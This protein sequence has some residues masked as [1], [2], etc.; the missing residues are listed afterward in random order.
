M[1]NKK[2]RYGIHISLIIIC[3][4][5]AFPAL[6]ALQVATL[7]LEEAFAIPP[8]LF[9]P[10]NDFFTNISDL[11]RRQ[12]FDS[13]IINTFIISMVVVIAKT[14]LAMLA[15]LALV[16]FRF[17]GRTILF[18]FILLTLLVPLE[19]IILP[20]LTMIAD[21]GW[22]AQNPRL[23]LSMPF[24]A[25]AI[26]VFIFR[27]HFSN[28]PR[29]LAEAAQ[30][31][32]ASALRF[33]YSVLFPM[34]WNVIGAHAVITFISM[35]NQYLFPIKLGL[36]PED[37]VVQVGVSQAVIVGSQTDFGLLMAAGV[38]ASVPPLILFIVLQKQFMS[39]F[40]LTRDK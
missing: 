20:L 4:F 28:I 31:D 24:L 18:F 32:G 16:F 25:G 35:W 37:Q 5:V 10:S 34:S 14:A 29:E 9:P 12:A 3:F 21:L 40:T 8:K 38:V 1:P 39:G 6:Y 13:F 23:A 17:P 15:G 27:Q 19:I 2:P 33:M 26:G 22:G 30:L 7:T 36:M 11:F